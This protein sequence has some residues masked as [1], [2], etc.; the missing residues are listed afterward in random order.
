MSHLH[1]TLPNWLPY[2][3]CLEREHTP[4]VSYTLS[5]DLSSHM[6]PLC[7][8][9]TAHC[10]EVVYFETLSVRAV[11]LFPPH[12]SQT[13]VC[14]GLLGRALWQNQFC[15]PRACSVCPQLT[16]GLFLRQR[17]GEYFR[18]RSGPNPG[19]RGSGD[20]AEPGPRD[21]AEWPSRCLLYLDPEH[22]A[23]MS[24]AG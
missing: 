23:R 22:V 14:S 13:V 7:S 24:D 8:L 19:R 5:E 3:F 11:R 17:C 1:H 20:I 12:F 6:Y 4:Q 9:C 2:T 15:W 16:P 18:I 21:L 10:H